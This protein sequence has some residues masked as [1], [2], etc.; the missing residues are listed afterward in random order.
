MNT[1]TTNKLVTPELKKALENYPLYSQDSKGAA[2]LCIAVFFLGKIRWYI[3][4][5]QAEGNDFTFFGI[6]TGLFDTEY[7]YISA[8]EL[9]DVNI[10][11]DGLD[12]LRVEQ[13]KTFK[14]CT[15]SEIDDVE[16]KSFLSRLYSK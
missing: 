10:D 8:N 15:I 14:P 11:N 6:V 1:T 16:L 5:G 13:D 4:E 9:E 2:A 12:T 3:L 7:G